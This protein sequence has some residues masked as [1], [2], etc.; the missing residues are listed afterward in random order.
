MVLSAQAEEV[1]WDEAEAKGW[2][3]NREGSDVSQDCWRQHGQTVEL[4]SHMGCV[5]GFG[6]IL[7][8]VDY[9]FFLDWNVSSPGVEM[10]ETVRLLPDKDYYTAVIFSQPG[11]DAQRNTHLRV[12][13][14]LRGPTGQVV[15]RE[16][17]ECWDG[18]PA[19]IGHELGLCLQYIQ[20]STDKFTVDGD[21]TV[22]AI[23][24]DYL[25]KVQVKLLKRVVFHR[26]KAE[27][28]PGSERTR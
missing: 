25:K 3:T 15:S 18:K 13:F 21:Y 7:D 8:L 11:V 14:R 5:G 28:V 27:L 19:P 17:L 24:K 4:P 2:H 20:F 10:P 12:D 1:A 23:V 9:Q 6:A 16:E 26:T 22:E